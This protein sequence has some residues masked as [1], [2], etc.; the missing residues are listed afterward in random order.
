MRLLINWFGSIRREAVFALILAALTIS[1]VA[2][3]IGASSAGC[4]RSKSRADVTEDKP[5]PNVSQEEAL[6]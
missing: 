5:A 6:P 2:I 3:L 1:L 4:R